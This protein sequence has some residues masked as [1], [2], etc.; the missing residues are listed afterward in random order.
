MVAS[1]RVTSELAAAEVTADGN[2]ATNGFAD[3]GSWGVRR[4]RK[5]ERAT[6]AKH[7]SAKIV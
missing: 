5:R 4:R 7:M 1:S 6:K 3:Q 2:P